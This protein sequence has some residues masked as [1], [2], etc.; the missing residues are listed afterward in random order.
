VYL[1]TI[2]QD[3]CDGCSACANACPAQIIELVGDKADLPNGSDECLGCE[4]CV[5]MCPNGAVEIREL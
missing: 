2:D 4:S 1:V 3:K 5:A